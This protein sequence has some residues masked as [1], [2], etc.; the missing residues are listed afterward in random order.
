[1]RLARQLYLLTRIS[2]LLLSL[3]PS[4]PPSFLSSQGAHLSGSQEPHPPTPVRISSGVEG[5][6]GGR[7]VC[8]KSISPASCQLTKSPPPS[9]LPST[10][11]AW[12]PLPD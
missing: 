9:L 6:E 2:F 1:M 10:I 11:D 3:P 12:T 7:K 5:R 4:L 8:S